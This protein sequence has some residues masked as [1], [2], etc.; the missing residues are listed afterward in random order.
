MI[1]SHPPLADTTRP[2]M[3]YADQGKRKLATLLTLL[4]TMPRAATNAL[5][6]AAEQLLLAEEFIL[7]VGHNSCYIRLHAGGLPAK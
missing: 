5:V 6:E 7:A 1:Q 2:T 4:S 3:W